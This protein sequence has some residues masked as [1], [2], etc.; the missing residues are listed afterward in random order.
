MD[1][2]NNNKC[3]FSNPNDNKILKQYNEY[4]PEED[5]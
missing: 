5:Y 1:I 4:Q 2:F 3:H